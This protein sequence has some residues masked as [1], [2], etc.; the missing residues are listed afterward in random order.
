MGGSTSWEYLIATGVPPH[1]KL[2]RIASVAEEGETARAGREAFNEVHWLPRALVNVSSISTEVELLG[3]RFS[4]P[5]GI[6]PMGISALTAYRGDIR[7]ASAAR[8]AGIPMVISASGL[9]ALETIAEV[10]PDVWYQAYMPPDPDSIHALV[11]RVARAG[12][13]I[14]VQLNSVQ[15]ARNSC[16]VLIPLSA[17]AKQ[18]ISPEDTDTV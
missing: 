17:I 11:A 13:Q 9:I 8:R 16:G 12:I 15:I 2:V 1:R 10:N 7:L 14:F 6:A 18:W 3:Q 5:F 4:Q